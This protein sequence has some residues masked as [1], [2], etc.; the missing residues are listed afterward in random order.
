MDYLGF[1]MMFEGKERFW[2]GL[3]GN[4]GFGFLLG[5]IVQRHDKE[6]RKE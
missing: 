2:F 1:W 3:E 5:T 4:K 6:I